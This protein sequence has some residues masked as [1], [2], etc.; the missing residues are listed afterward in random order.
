MALSSI[1][2]ATN[3][4]PGV[5]LRVSLGVGV[6]SSGASPRHLVVF[7]NKTS[8]GTMDLIKEYDCLSEDDARELAGAG[9]ELFWNV[10]AA[11]DA[12]P[13]VLLKIIAVAESTGTAATGTLVVGG[14]ATSAGTIGV[15]VLGE[16]VEV[17][18]ANGD[19]PTA[20]GAAL[21]AAINAKPD[22]P[23]TAA[24]AAGTVTVTARH[25]GPRGNFV[26][27]RARLLAGSGVTITPPASGSLTAGATSDDPQAALDVIAAVRRTYL[28]SPYVDATQL[29]K[30]KAHVDAEDEP[31]VGHRKQLVFGSIDTLAN[32]TT[33]TT[34]L[35]LARAQCAWQEKADATPGMLAAALAARRAAREAADAGYN[36]DGE[37]IP[38]LRPHYN[39]AD[40]PTNSELISALNNGITPLS[41]TPSGEVFVVRSITTK[42]QDATAKPDYRV[43]DTAKVTVS[44]EIADRYEL[45]YADRWKGFK[46]SDDPPEGEVAPV[47]VVTPAMCNDL[48]YEILITAEESDGLLQSGS[49]ER[50]KGEIFHALSTTSPGRFDGT[51]PLDVIEG[52][53]QFATDIRQIG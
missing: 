39:S 32:T 43:L 16:E 34:G 5:F 15:S 2:A 3:K 21:V 4:V 14:A 11:I 18:F 25:K 41:S 48:A 36:F 8:T 22:W 7:G 47:N 28:V 19:V 33:L 9:S 31:E 51:V 49:V 42:S 30:F 40:I 1:L 29:A 6:R 38:G 37:I 44:D 12:Y 24:N 26:S 45:A 50:R 23:L 20:V 13:G 35:N 52:A 17:P 46:A 10:K 27:V 53:H